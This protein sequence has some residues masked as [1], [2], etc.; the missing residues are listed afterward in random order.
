[1]SEV[2]GNISFTGEKRKAATIK[3]IFNSINMDMSTDEV[4]SKFEA[5]D[6]E[7]VKMLQASN[8]NGKNLEW[9]KKYPEVAERAK[10]A[11]QFAHGDDWKVW[12]NPDLCIEECFDPIHIKKIPKTDNYSVNVFAGSEAPYLCTFLCTILEKMGAENI[13]LNLQ[14]DSE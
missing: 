3:K 6:P 11:A 4:F 9:A 10:Q 2:D 5:V 12:Q 14:Y 13:T 8:I 1:M 7:I